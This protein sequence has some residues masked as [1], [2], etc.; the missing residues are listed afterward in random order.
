[1]AIDKGKLGYLLQQAIGA[2]IRSYAMIDEVRKLIAPDDSPE[3]CQQLVEN[4]VADYVDCSA[5]NL[6]PAQVA[7]IGEDDA[8]T[9]LEEWIGPVK[10]GE[11]ET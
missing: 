8:N 10:K 2:R 9:L 6:S 4:A 1:M 11:K 3:P 7:L 5:L